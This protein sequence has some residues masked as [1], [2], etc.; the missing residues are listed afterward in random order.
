MMVAVGF[1][2]RT[3]PSVAESRSDAGTVPFALKR[4]YATRPSFAF[5]RGLK[6]TATILLSLREAEALLPLELLPSAF[7]VPRT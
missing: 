2:P 4:H 1:S 5:A 3:K 7:T 6:P